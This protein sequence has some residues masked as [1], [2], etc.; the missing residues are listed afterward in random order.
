VSVAVA[1]SLAALG[2]AAGLFGLR[3][4]RG[5]S[6]ADRIVALDAL[7]VTIASGIGVQA[8]GSKEGTFLNVLVVVS[9]LAFVGTV[10]VAGFIERRQ[11]EEP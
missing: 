3:L 4:L 10:T 9:L 5:P 8:A 2:A 11:E 1:A 6:L 7:L